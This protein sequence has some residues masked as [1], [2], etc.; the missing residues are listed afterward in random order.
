[1]NC[2]DVLK[3][4][5]SFGSAQFRKTYA[6]HGVCGP[7]Y[8]VSYKHLGTLTKLLRPNHALALELWA[9]GN[10]DARVLATM[11]AEPEKL[12][13]QV[14]D[15]WLKDM[16]NYAIGDAFA[17]VVAQSPLAHKKAAKW[18][19][20]KSEMISNAGWSVTARLVRL[21]PQWK[22]AA[23]AALLDEIEAR[24]HAAPNRTRYAMNS[25]VI[26]IGVRNAS[27][28]KLALAAA[29]RIGKVEVDYG[30]TSCQTPDAATY[31]KKTVAHQQELARKQAK[32]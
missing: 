24:I 1:M 11:I 30:D 20:A 27:M 10:H 19:A 4:L 7:M 25:T 15:R 26:S 13:G 9:S 6:R 12:T 23:L 17:G 5:E 14:I 8:G 29:K 21:D 32:R 22:D 31:I 28:Q 2:Q 16:D 18:R 3:K